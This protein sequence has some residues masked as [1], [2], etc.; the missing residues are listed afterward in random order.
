MANPG[1]T[2]PLRVTVAVLRLKAV[3]AAG[4]SEIA[5]TAKAAQITLVMSLPSES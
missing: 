2:V 1:P 4:A 5:A 3:V